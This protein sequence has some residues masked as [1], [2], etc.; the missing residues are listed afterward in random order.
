MQPEQPEQRYDVS[1]QDYWAYKGHEVVPVVLDGEVYWRIDGRPEWQY[2]L[3]GNALN[4]I[5]S[6]HNFWANR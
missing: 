4:A 1:G 5:E 2:K 3:L 6:M